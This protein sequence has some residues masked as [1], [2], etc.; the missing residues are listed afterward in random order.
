[1]NDMSMSRAS[2]IGVLVSTAGV[3]DFP[4]T[5]KRITTTDDGRLQ[6]VMEA[7]SLDDESLAKVRRM[8]ELQRGTSLLT[9]ESAQGSL[10][11]EV[12]TTEKAP[13]PQ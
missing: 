1:M 13:R 4:V 5:I 7:Q 10:F 8:L 12:P 3:R 6:L 9:L 2:G 11:V